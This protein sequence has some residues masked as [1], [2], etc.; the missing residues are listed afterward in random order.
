ME[1]SN[2]FVCDHDAWL[3]HPGSIIVSW[4]MGCIS[5]CHFCI[6]MPYIHPRHHPTALSPMWG[7]MF[8][9]QTLPMLGYRY[10]FDNQFL[11]STFRKTKI[12]CVNRFLSCRLL[13]HTKTHTHTHTHT[14]E[15]LL[16][17]KRDWTVGG[18]WNYGT[19]S[20]HR[21][22]S[23]SLTEAESVTHKFPFMLFN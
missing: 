9:Q 16:T 8:K 20:R 19:G 2:T 11:C 17:L 6:D 13:Q 1:W 14:Q 10:A 7:V 5:Y 21:L 23:T 12:E 4:Q 22:W 3:V 18:P 15:K